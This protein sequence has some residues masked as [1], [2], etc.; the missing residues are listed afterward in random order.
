MGDVIPFIDPKE[1]PCNRPGLRKSDGPWRT[2]DLKGRRPVGHRPPTYGPRGGVLLAIDQVWV[3]YHS[4]ELYV[5]KDLVYTRGTYY[6]YDVVLA[7]Y[8]Q[9]R[10]QR[11]LAEG[12]LRYT[13][14]IWD[15]FEADR[16]ERVEELCELAEND[17][18]SP[19]R[20]TGTA[21]ASALSFFGLDGDGY[22][23]D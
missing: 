23:I 21:G 11:V 17:P 3:E 14:Q 6:S 7:A 8:K 19:W 10:V 12:T 9:E 4:Q 18:E 22:R 5:I 1:W 2:I 13:M 15:Q 20:G 16:K